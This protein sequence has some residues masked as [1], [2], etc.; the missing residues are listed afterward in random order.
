MANRGLGLFPGEPTLQGLVGWGF[1]PLVWGMGIPAE[2][3]AWC[4]ELMGTKTVLNEFVAYLTLA[5]AGGG[6]IAAE[7]R[8]IL[9]YAMC[10]F[11]NFGSLGILVG[12]LGSLLP[13]R[14]AEL[15]GLGVRAMVAG[16]LA[17]CTT[18]ALAALL[19]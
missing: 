18:G 5:N 16:T 11:A 6:P 1:R 8:T 7:S 17:T 2:D 4:A 9:I 10:G 19:I 15:F 14:R 12:G 3:V 13:D